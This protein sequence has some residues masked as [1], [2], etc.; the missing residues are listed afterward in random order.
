MH[1]VYS[2]GIARVFNLLINFS[3]KYVNYDIRQ[4]KTDERSANIIFFLFILSTSY[5]TGMAA[6]YTGGLFGVVG[7]IL[8]RVF[9][10]LTLLPLSLN[11]VLFVEG[12]LRAEVQNI[13]SNILRQ[14]FNFTGSTAVRVAYEVGRVMQGNF[15]EQANDFANATIGKAS[16]ESA[17][18]GSG[19]TPAEMEQVRE[20]ANISLNSVKTGF[21]HSRKGAAFAVAGLGFSSVATLGVATPLLLMASQAVLL[22]L[23]LWFAT[24]IVPARISITRTYL[25]SVAT[26]WSARQL[27]RLRLPAPTLV[28]RQSM[29]KTDGT[30]VTYLS[31]EQIRSRMSLFI[32]LLFTVGVI[33]TMVRAFSLAE[34]EDMS[35]LSNSFSN[36]LWKAAGLLTLST[37]A[38]VT[39]PAA[40][41]LGATG[42]SIVTARVREGALGQSKIYIAA[43]DVALGS[44]ACSAANGAMQPVVANISRGSIRAGSAD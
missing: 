18:A 17:L 28:V 36:F 24:R 11:I 44:T 27:V 40:E 38:T 7:Y 25:S 20:D 10:T 34:N 2:M 14:A 35:D 4:K 23:L 22:F 21:G 1:W 43:D 13:V 5:F 12:R 29:L 41:V 16:I 37:V 33:Y 9:A 19:M 3:V 30:S 32:T 31:P 6:W 8:T 15:A 42:V 39:A 26:E